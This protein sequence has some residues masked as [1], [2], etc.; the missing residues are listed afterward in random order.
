MKTTRLDEAPKVDKTFSVERRDLFANKLESMGI[1][2]RE[3]QYFVAADVLD[4]VASELR[5]CLHPSFI[6]MTA[7]FLVQARGEPTKDEWTGILLRQVAYFCYGR[8][9]A[10]ASFFHGACD[11]LAGASAP[12]HPN[13]RPWRFGYVTIEKIMRMRLT[14]TAA[15]PSSSEE[16]T[17]SIR[18]KAV[19]PEPDSP[20]PRDD[21]PTTPHL[22]TSQNRQHTRRLPDL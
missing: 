15:H 20:R 21:E 11:A 19:I 5:G 7:K 6:A 17:T 13:N 9:D 8:H 10:L 14:T 4:G 12:R 1:E 22:G 3:M 2:L 16:D 18:P